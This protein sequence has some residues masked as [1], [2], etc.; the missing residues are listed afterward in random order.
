MGSELPKQLIPLGEKPIIV[1]TLERFLRFDPQ[2][3]AC[4]VLH[5][6]LISDWPSF[7]QKHFPEAMGKR[8]VHCAGGSERTT[9]VQ[10][11]L[12]TLE[13]EGAMPESL[14]AIHDAVRPFVRRKMLLEA[15]TTAEEKGN[16]VVCV[17]VKSSLRQKIG[18]GSQAV[19][20]SLYFQVQTPQVFKFSNIWAAYAQRPHDRFTD[21]ASLAEW[22]GQPVHLCEGSYQNIKVTTLEDLIVAEIILKK[23][24]SDP[25]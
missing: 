13:K 22:A 19:D 16:A 18:E 21:D 2:L 8:I 25:E 17:A 9:S 11:G 15:Y 1:H 3:I 6:S 12:N 5:A 20:R 24:N 7:V 10:N 23:W 14:V 4:V